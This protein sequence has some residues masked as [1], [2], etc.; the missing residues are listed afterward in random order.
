MALRSRLWLLLI[1][2]IAA[3]TWL[4]RPIPTYSDTDFA[5]IT[6]DPIAGEIVY[7]TSNCFGCHASNPLDPR[8]VTVLSGGKTFNGPY[9]TSVVPNIS[10]DQ[11]AGI[12]AWSKADFANAVARG[13]RPDGR[14]LLPVHPSSSYYKATRQDLADLFAFIRTLPDSP[15]I[16]EASDLKFPFNLE[17]TARFWRWLRHKPN[18]ATPVM[19]DPEYMRGRYLVE[20][21]GGCANCHTPRTIFGTLDT[22]RWMA[23]RN[24]RSYDPVGALR[25][26]NLTPAGL[27]WTKDEI[28]NYLQQGHSPAFEPARGPMA[29]ITVNMLHVPTEDLAAIATYLKALKP[30]K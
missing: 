20:A 21:L 1:P 7:R 26:K 29:A 28:V 15:N 18:Y 10:G 30:V 11:S 24:P 19:D 17:I 12:G 2:A 25:S 23:G 13:V 8:K 27:S 6:G 22:G 5:N 3:L 4:F 9:G 14:V 16:P